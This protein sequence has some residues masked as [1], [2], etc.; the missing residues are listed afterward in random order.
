MEHARLAQEIKVSLFALNLDAGPIDGQSIIALA[1]AQS[2][3][4]F[5]LQMGLNYAIIQKVLHVS[6][7]VHDCWMSE[8]ICL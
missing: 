8:Y 7:L 5:I 6:R 2:G 1:T 4:L 3:N